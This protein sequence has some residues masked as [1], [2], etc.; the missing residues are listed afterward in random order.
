M[1]TLAKL[2]NL[3]SGLDLSSL[4]LCMLLYKLADVFLLLPLY[5]A[6]LVREEIVR[7]GYVVRVTLRLHKTCQMHVSHRLVLVLHDKNFVL[8]QSLNEKG[9][10]LSCGQQA[11]FVKQSVL[12]IWLPYHLRYRG[13]RD[14]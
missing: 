8:L 12:C 5:A 7:V 4:L 10:F 2:L 9:V 13:I 3:S 6:F 1:S 11:F 14:R